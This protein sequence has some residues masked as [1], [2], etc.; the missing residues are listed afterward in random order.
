MG[1]RCLKKTSATLHGSAHAATHA[2]QNERHTAWESN[3]YQK[4]SATLHGSADAA[5]TPGQPATPPPTPPGS[6]KREP[7][8][9]RAFGKN[10]LDN[11][12]IKSRDP[13][14]GRKNPPLLL[15]LLWSDLDET[16]WK[17]ILGPSRTFLNSPGPQKTTKSSF[18]VLSKLLTP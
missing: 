2:D 1:A 16:L 18:T 4:M 7:F 11:F 3:L 10:P 8:V 17:L 15:G 14:G 5:L 12:T 6:T 13:V 9:R